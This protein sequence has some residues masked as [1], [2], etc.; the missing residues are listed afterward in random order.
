MRV[1]IFLPDVAGVVA[2]RRGGWC[3][4]RESVRAA[5][6]VNPWAGKADGVN[7]WA[8]KADGVNPWARWADGTSPWVRWAD[9]TSPWARW[10]DGVNPWARWR[11]TTYSTEVVV[12]DSL[13]SA[14]L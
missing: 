4:S 1:E 9:G 10:T 11:V 5:D 8:G 2:R 6:G 12:N 7:P 13:W 3:G 14:R